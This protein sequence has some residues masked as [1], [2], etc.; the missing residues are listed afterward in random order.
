MFMSVT[1]IRSAIASEMERS[2]RHLPPPAARRSLREAAGLSTSTL[3]DILGVTR[4]TIRNWE[5]GERS[6][7]GDLLA[8]YLEA[9]TAMREAV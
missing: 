1:S 6:P 9:L 2:Q 4:Q 5:S 8:A 3:A 7:R